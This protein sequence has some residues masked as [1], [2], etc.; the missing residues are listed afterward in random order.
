MM[1]WERGGSCGD[2]EEVGQVAPRGQIREAADGVG[3]GLY[4]GDTVGLDRMEGWG[5][6]GSRIDRICIAFF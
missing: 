3:V 6:R 1:C 4:L 2:G 5:S